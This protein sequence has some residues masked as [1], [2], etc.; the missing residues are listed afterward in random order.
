MN[1][2]DLS[3]LEVLLELFEHDSELLG[4]HP[5][6]CQQHA[7]KLPLCDPPIHRVMPLE[8][9]GQGKQGSENQEQ[10]KA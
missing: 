9:Q 8:L 6:V 1:T 7:P 2:T 5:A 3:I 4:L 10:Q